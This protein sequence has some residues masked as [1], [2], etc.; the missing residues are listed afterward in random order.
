MNVKQ[1]YDIII[2]G[3]GPAGLSMACLLGQAG[4]KTAL[5]DNLPLK[6]TTNDMRTTAISYGSSKVLER[7][8]FWPRLA[9]LSCPI[10]DVHILDGDSPMLLRFMSEEVDGKPFGWI[11]ENADMRACALAQLKT[12]KS[13]T[14]LTKTSVARYENAPDYVAVVLDNGQELRASLVIGADGRG[15]MTR[16]HMGVQEKSWDY[17]HRAVICTVSHD[18]PHNN[19]AVEHFYPEGPFAV[20]PMCDDVDGRHRSNVVF[21]EHGPKSQSRL[22]YSPETFQMAMQVRF[23]ENYGEVRALMAPKAYPLNFIHAHRYIADRMALIA[24]AAHGIHPI[25]GQG[26][27]LGYRDIDALATLL[28]AAKDTGQD[29]GDPALLEDYERARRL[30]NMGM[31]AFTDAMVRLFSNDLPP[32]RFARRAGLKLVSKLQPAKQFFMRKAMGE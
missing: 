11:A 9:P 7:A 28:E 21:T 20:L 8:G 16:A 26:L 3:A 17:E 27:N 32:V 22:R 24:D 5:V 14:H 4:I 1:F 18:K 15:S 10:E 12:H 23:P 6:I 31:A 2:V 13:V 30:D 19:V 29:F 25:A